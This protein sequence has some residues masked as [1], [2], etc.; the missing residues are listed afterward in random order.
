MKKAT[1]G[2]KPK[3][4]GR[5]IPGASL[6][7]GLRAPMMYQGPKIATPRGVITR[8]ANGMA[9]LVWN[10]GF[11]PKLQSQFTSAQKFLDSEILR[12][13]EPY[14]PFRTG[15]LVMSGI[16]GTYIGSGLVSWIAPYA[17]RQYYL[18]RATKGLRGPFWFARWKPVGAQKAIAGARKIAGG[19]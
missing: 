9:Q 13:C 17:H 18:K 6:K 12:G 15:M 2:W 11:Q 3:F 1:G 19:R 7:F 5:S 4:R 10:P 14:I 8:K 16:L